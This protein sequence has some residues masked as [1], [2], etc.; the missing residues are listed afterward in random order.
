LN[1]L[2]LPNPGRYKKL[3]RHK[4]K[5]RTRTDHLSKNASYISNV[6]KNGTYEKKS[7]LSGRTTKYTKTGRVSKR[8]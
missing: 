4:N 2:G 7:R 6:N 5:P 1:R 8:Q 3:V